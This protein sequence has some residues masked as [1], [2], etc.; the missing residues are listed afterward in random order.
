MTMLSRA[1]VA[2]TYIHNLLS[3]ETREMTSTKSCSYCH[4]DLIARSGEARR[5]NLFKECYETV[6]EADIERSQVWPINRPERKAEREA[7]LAK[8]VD[9]FI[10]DKE[11]DE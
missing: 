6:P 4:K 10:S 8:L 1:R 5:L 3:E 7:E 9:M 2:K 11:K